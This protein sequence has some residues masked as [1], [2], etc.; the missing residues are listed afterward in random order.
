MLATIITNDRIT[1]MLL[2]EDNNLI[3]IKPNSKRFSQKDL[4][5]LEKKVCASFPEEYVNFLRK[6]N[7]GEVEDNIIELPSGEIESFILS[8]FFG[9]RL[10]DID[11]LLSCYDTFEGRIPK[12]SIPIGRDVGGDIV[13][14][15]LNREKYGYIF[16][17][18]HDIELEF[19]DNEMEIQDLYYVAPSFDDFLHMIIR[20]RRR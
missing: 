1:M 14:L 12:G 20:S 11:D 3:I 17:W 19:E 13:C 9:T 4:N 6:Y 5:E 18:D 8:S 15:N 10:E 2:K 16:L 7:G